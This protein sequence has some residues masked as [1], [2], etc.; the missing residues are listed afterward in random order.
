MDPHL[1]TELQDSAQARRARE[2]RQLCRQGRVFQDPQEEV[3]EDLGCRGRLRVSEGR[4][5]QG[6]HRWASRV[7]E[8]PRQAS[9]LVE[10]HVSTIYEPTWNCA[11]LRFVA[12]FPPGGFQP[13]PGGRG[14]A[15]P[16]GFPGR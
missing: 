10:H 15:P 14:F 4:V 7:E 1:P 2:H 9:H 3:S 13:P 8:D 5:F 12:G 6:R 11:D 16:G